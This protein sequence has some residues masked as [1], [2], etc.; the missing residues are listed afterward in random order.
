MFKLL[1]T[2]EFPFRVVE[3]PVKICKL[4][5]RIWRGGGGGMIVKAEI[6]KE[7]ESEKENTSHASNSVFQE[8]QR[9]TSNLP[10]KTLQRQ[11]N[12][13]WIVRKVLLVLKM[14]WLSGV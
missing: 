1:T 4:R 5:R 9:N 10:S 11:V 8:S 14:K 12:Q 13:G 6:G 3:R 7:G 2:C